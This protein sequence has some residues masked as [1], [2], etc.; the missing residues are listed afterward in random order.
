MATTSTAVPRWAGHSIASRGPSPRQ[1]FR[2][3]IVYALLI[4][5]GL[6]LFTPF[7]LAFLGSFKSDAEIVAY[8]PRML[9]AQWQTENWARLFTTDFGGLPRPEGTTSLGLMTGLFTFFLTFL[10]TS[11]NYTKPRREISQRAGLALGSAL[12]VLAGLATGFYLKTSFEASGVIMVTVSLAVTIITLLAVGIIGLSR[13]NWERA[14][15]ALAASLLLGA[16]VTLIF[17]QAALWAGGGRFI[18][19][20]FNTAL[21]SVIRAVVIV[22]FCSMAA[23]AFARMRF[24]GK[25]LIFNFMLASMM[26][27]SAV[28][29]VPAFV[30]IAKLG[31]VNSAYSLII[32]VLVNAFS[33]F[34]LTQFLKTIPKELEEAA[35]VDG[36]SFF[37]IYKDV[38]LPLARPVLLTVFILQFQGMWNDFLTPLLY[39]NTPDMWVLNVGLSTFQQEYKAQWNITLVGAMVNALVPLTIF[40][41]FSKYY[42][43]GASY[44][45]L[46]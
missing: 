35:F 43:E 14:I 1:R 17:Q 34:T 33:I 13:P 22:I 41:F 37:Q 18:R 44:S 46:K 8:P 36:A 32:P 15:L 10:L 40:F 24:P 9:P 39:L 7:I 25:S 27:P 20:L 28:T 2:R 4:A 5:I 31:W 11:L 42:I 29:L 23:F 16:A 19:W 21:L 12:A 26:I 38:V 6:A 30:L 45:G 3:L